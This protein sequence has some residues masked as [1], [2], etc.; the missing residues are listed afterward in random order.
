MPRAGTGPPCRG[1][2]RAARSTRRAIERAGPDITRAAD[3]LG[4]AEA[5]LA[6]VDPAGLMAPL[7]RLVGDAKDEIDTRA[8]QAK[9]AS[10]LAGLLPPMLGVE[11][12]RTYLLVTL[13][14]S[15]PRGSGGY[16]G[17]YGLL[18]VDG[19]RLSLSHLA[20]TSEIPRCRRWTGPPTPRRRGGGP[21]IDRIFWDTTYTPDFPTAAGFMKGIWEAGGG[22][23]VDGVIA[24]DPALMASLLQVVGPVD[25][26]A[27][28]ETITADN[29][30]QIVGA[31]VYKTTSRSSPTRG[32]SASARRCGTRCFTRPWPVKEM[33]T[34]V[35][36]ATADGTC[37]SG[38]PIPARR[39]RW[40]RWGR[41][42]R[43]RCPTDGSPFV[44]VTG[45]TANRAGYYATWDTKVEQARTTRGDRRWSRR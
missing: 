14:P 9:T 23:P 40:P 1:S 21:G 44:L 31:D 5:E 34:A 11:E 41:P 35:G 13:S 22:K 24:G 17:V 10:T 7:D 2:R 37:R 26:P 28:P 18:H 45:F 29:V 27:W 20:P 4:Q 19:R 12:A 8:E 39:P 33:A 32:R 3:L 30:E 38:A 25:T 42:A 36:G 16:P 6:A 15:D 43:C